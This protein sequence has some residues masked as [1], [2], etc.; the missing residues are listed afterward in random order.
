MSA[1]DVVC[2]FCGTTGE[3]CGSWFQCPIAFEPVCET[4][5][6]KCKYHKEMGSMSFCDF[7]HSVDRAKSIRTG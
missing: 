3:T 2:E 7:R 5:H 1:K 6:Y 4:C